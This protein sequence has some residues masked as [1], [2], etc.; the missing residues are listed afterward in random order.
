MCEWSGYGCEAA[1]RH[2]SDVTDSQPIG[3]QRSTDCT[4]VGH[5]SL[6]LDSTN[7]HYHTTT[8]PQSLIYHSSP[9]CSR[10]S[11]FPSVASSLLPSPSLAPSLPLRGDAGHSDERSNGYAAAV[12]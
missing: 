9:H 1:V 5:T 4:H 11:P 12:E 2:M 8:L 7:Y 3:L 10:S 6:P